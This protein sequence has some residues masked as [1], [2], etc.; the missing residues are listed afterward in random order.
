M[1]KNNVIKSVLILFLL[2]LPLNV[3]ADDYLRGDCDLNGEV[4]IADVTTLIDYLLSGQWPDEVEPETV[5]YVVNG[6][7]L[8]MLRVEGGTFTM[9]ASEGDPDA[10]DNEYPAHIVHLS[11]YYIGTTEVTQ[12]LWLAVMGS[13]PSVCTDSELC[14]VENVSWEMCQEF[15]TKLNEITGKNFR[16]PTEAE[17]EFAARGG[18]MSNGYKYAGSNDINEVAWN[19]GNS[20]GKSHPVATKAPNEL[21]LYDMSGNVSEY[22]NDWYLSRYP[23]EEQTNPQGPDEA[24]LRVVRDGYYNS[25]QCRVTQRNGTQ[26]NNRLGGVAG[27]RLAL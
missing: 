1:K 25:R 10:K 27:L 16:L 14:P 20:G 5:T 23:A 11:T 7:E 21:G 2:A 17:W 15:I 9:G 12:Q 4:S 24:N 18:N 19:E 13:N 6:V 22:C 8:N 26:P 3:L